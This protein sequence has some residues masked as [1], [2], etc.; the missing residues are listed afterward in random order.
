MKHQTYTIGLFSNFN[1]IYESEFMTIREVDEL[2]SEYESEEELVESYSKLLNK[3]FSNC[4]PIIIHYQNKEEKRSEEFGPMIFNEDK[5]V[6]NEKLTMKLA[7]HYSDL[8][9]FVDELLN[10]YQNTR[11][12]SDL[13]RIA[14]SEIKEDEE[15]NRSNYSDHLKEFLNYF[16]IYKSKRDLYFFIKEYQ[17]ENNIPN[18]LETSEELEKK[19]IEQTNRTNEKII[20]DNPTILADPALVEA[21]RIAKECGELAKKNID[22]E[23][24]RSEQVEKEKIMFKDFDAFLDKAKA[25][26]DAA[27]QLKNSKKINTTKDETKPLTEEELRKDYLEYLYNNNNIDE[28]VRDNSIE[29]LEIYNMGIVDGVTERSKK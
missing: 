18:V 15:K 8:P 22:E 16:D 26:R 27:I 25:E 5:D 4:N 3:D 12:F 19:L 28:L 23:K 1:K 24:L 14:R 2:T 21:L 20:L 9:S 7:Y 10:K 13:V 6:L 17:K 11:Y 29:E